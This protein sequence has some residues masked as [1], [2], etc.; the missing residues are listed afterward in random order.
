MFI[1]FLKLYG[2]TA[3]F[4]HSMFFRGERG[5]GFGTS[6][7]PPFTTESFEMGF[8]IMEK[9]DR[10]GEQI[11]CCQSKP[12]LVLSELNPPQRE[13]KMK[14]AE[15]LPLKAYT[16]NSIIMMTLVK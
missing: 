13:V 16:L 11:L 15:L 1:Y 2:Y 12:P 5:V 9:F 8:L 7:L 10:K 4:L 3:M 6:C 14:M